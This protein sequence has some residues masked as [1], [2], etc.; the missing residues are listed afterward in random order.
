MKKNMIEIIR[1]L[2]KNENK[3]GERKKKRRKQK[4]KRMI[5]QIDR[6]KKN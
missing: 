6:L 2:L 4:K 5:R 3:K 1:K